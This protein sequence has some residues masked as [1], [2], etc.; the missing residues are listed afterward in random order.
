M[1]RPIWRGVVTFG[2]VSIPVKLFAATES[3][4]V[5][6]HLLHGECNSRLKQMRWCPVCETEVP[7]SEVVRG[8]EHAREQ[9]VVLTD[10]DMEKLPLP[11]KHTIELSA[12]VES[13]EVDPVFYEKSYYL[14]PEETALKPFALLM[15]ALKE[16]QRVGIGKIAIREKERLCALR[17]LDGNLVMQT[18]LRAD[19][20]RVS[21]ATAAPAVDLTDREM[22]MAFTL[23]DLMS[24][25]FAPDKYPD[26]YRAA[27]TEIIE[28]KLQGQE[29]AEV[30]AA[31]EAKVIDLMEALKASVEAARKRKQTGAAG[32][33]GPRRAS[34]G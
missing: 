8:Y 3:K 18:L 7:W 25:P 30:V 15:R 34:A 33:A 2:M 9:Y 1:S 16:R 13:S 17:P 12:F 32:E 20:V 19:E 24:E 21:E 22:S 26:Q 6:M 29:L 10:E 11:S 27:L 4:D 14:E 23:V 5:S 31:P 28:A